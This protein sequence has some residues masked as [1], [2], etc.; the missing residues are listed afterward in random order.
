MGRRPPDLQV[1]REGGSVTL[2]VSPE[3][4]EKGAY[5]IGAWIRDSMAGIGTMTY[6]DPESGAFGALG[7]GITD[8]DTALLMPLPPDPF[9]PPP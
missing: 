4:N 3:Q 2:S 9:C 5:C 7:H 8:A 1:R 6:Y